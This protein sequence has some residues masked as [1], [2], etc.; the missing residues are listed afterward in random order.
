MKRYSFFGLLLLLM[1]GCH[2]ETTS[3]M[4]EQLLREARTQLAPD[5]RTAVFDVTYALQGNDVILHGEILGDQR[6]ADF[7]AF[8]RGKTSYTVLDSLK[9]LP[10][11]S[12]GDKPV[13]IVSVSVSN[14]RKEPDHA[15]E[16]GTQALLGTPVR[17]LKKHRG[18]WYVQTPDEYLGWTDDLM[19]RMDAAEYSAWQ[20]KPR[21]IVT[22]AF[23][24]THASPAG[25]SQVV[26]DVVAG[27][28]LV[29]DKIAG[30]WYQVLYPDGRKA[31]LPMTAAQPY[32]RWL[33][34]AH[35][36]PQ[37]IIATAK[38]YTGI[39][40]LWGGTS[41]KGFDCSGFTKTVYFLNGVMLPRDAD[42]QAAVGVP[43]ATDTGF[44]TLQPGDLL[45]FG[46]RGTAE[47]PERIT[48]VGISLGRAQF[49]HAPGGGGVTTNSLSPEDLDFSRHRSDT[50]VRA[51]RII[52]AGRENGIIH[53][54][55][56]PYYQ[57]HER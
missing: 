13:A 31:F 54:S 1:T 9:T 20:E 33:A 5:R 11:S 45:F 51:R 29:L 16:L 22:E 27:D 49:I 7:L 47:K 21:V 23:G 48:H 30:G 12:V 2:H 56:L 55:S 50:F 8:F 3:P 44:S 28:L 39:P 18:W 17:V 4:I 26:S 52:G 57:S 14:L 36:T 46:R 43:V 10:D 38:Q 42:Q 15:A 25:S 34:K 24:F 41:S 32:D 53:L 19:V 37:S 35:D 6:K 40:Y